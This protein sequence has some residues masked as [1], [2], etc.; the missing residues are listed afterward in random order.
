[1]QKKHINCPQTNLNL[2]E[3]NHNF[4]PKGHDRSL[5]QLFASLPASNTWHFIWTLC[6]RHLIYSL[7][8]LVVHPSQWEEAM[9]ILPSQPVKC[10]EQK[11]NEPKDQ[12]L[13]FSH[14]INVLN[15]YCME[16]KFAA[17]YHTLYLFLLL[18]CRHT[19]QQPTM[20]I[21]NAAFK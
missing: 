7:A 19:T 10:I 5:D 15:H 17:L 12:K 14:L 20:V 9:N 2:L 1:M 11:E 21:I 13:D 8:Q 4:R 3:I 18:S 16:S 6:V